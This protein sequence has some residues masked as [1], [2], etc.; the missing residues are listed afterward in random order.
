MVLAA[1]LTG[2]ADDGVATGSSGAGHAV[3][4]AVFEVV[5]VAAPSVA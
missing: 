1:G 5:A 2:M 3:A 4:A